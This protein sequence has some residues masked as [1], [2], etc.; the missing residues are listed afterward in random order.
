MSDRVFIVTG[1][2]RGIGLACAQRLIDDGHRVVLADRDA[3]AGLAASRDL[4]A[5]TDR[6]IFVECDVSDPLSVH[7]LSLIHI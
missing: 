2:A 6:A 1:A 5:D 3:A 7:N 4:A